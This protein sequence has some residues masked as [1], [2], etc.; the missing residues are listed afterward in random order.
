MV[1]DRVLMLSFRIDINLLLGSLSRFVGC[2]S[3]RVNFK[4][5]FEHIA[6]QM[7]GSIF[8]YFGENSC[9]G[10]EGRALR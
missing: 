10:I 7:L 8:D 4:Y 3:L 2:F 5:A 1:A 6:A 9:L